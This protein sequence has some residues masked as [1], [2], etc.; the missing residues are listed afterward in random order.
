MQFFLF[1]FHFVIQ[2]T[3]TCIAMCV[4]MESLTL[5]PFANMDM[6]IQ[7]AL[8]GVEA[9]RMHAI[10]AWSMIQMVRRYGLESVQYMKTMNLDV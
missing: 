8:K 9:M 4:M 6:R 3:A 1:P 7:R 2:D 10:S 5:I